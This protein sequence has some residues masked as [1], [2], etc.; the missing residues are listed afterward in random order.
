VSDWEEGLSKPA[1]I[2][3]RWL[4]D[5]CYN[6]GGSVN[7]ALRVAL[8]GSA[9]GTD[10]VYDGGSAVDIITPDYKGLMV[11]GYIYG[12]GEFTAFTFDADQRLRVDAEVSFSATELDVNID[13]LDGDSAGIWAYPDGNAANTPVPVNSTADGV[14]RTVT[15]FVGIETI[16]YNEVSVLTGAET[17]VLSY[18]V[19]VATDYHAISIPCSGEADGIFILKKNGAT[20]GKKRNS[21]SQRNVDF[22]FEY[23]LKFQAADVISVSVLH[24]NDGACLFNASFYGEVEP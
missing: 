22:E 11:G 19:P 13:A 21:W 8:S 18:V 1:D 10:V 7:G 23:G 12:T 17:T 20:I 15:G 4:H 6:N 9:F 2:T 5:Y 14:I 3:S 24:V 16:L